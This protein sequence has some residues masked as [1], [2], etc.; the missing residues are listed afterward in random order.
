MDAKHAFKDAGAGAKDRDE[1]QLLAVDDFCF[2]RLK[3][4]FDVDLLHPHIARHLIGHEHRQLVE[5]ATKTVGAR[6]L[7]PHEREL[8]LYEGMI[9][10]VDVCHVQLLF[11]RRPGEGRGPWLNGVLIYVEF[12]IPASPG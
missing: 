11:I 1:H 4:R 10:Q 9:D 12:W 3:R 6:V 5:Q 8:V 7:A 2:H